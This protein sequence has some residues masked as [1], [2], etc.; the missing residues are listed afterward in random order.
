MRKQSTRLC[1]APAAMTRSLTAAAL[2]LSEG[3]SETN[4]DGRMAVIDAPTEWS[5][6]ASLFVYLIRWYLM[7]PKMY[8][9]SAAARA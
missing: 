1:H 4:A 8:T 9:Y 3:E 6:T 5:D 7:E 2:E